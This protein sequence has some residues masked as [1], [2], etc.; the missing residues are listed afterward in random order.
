[1]RDSGASRRH[2]PVRFR[3]DGREG[4]RVESVGL[5]VG[6]GDGREAKASGFG[7]GAHHV[8]DHARLARVIEVQDIKQ[9]KVK[10]MMLGVRRRRRDY[11]G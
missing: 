6:V 7:Q 5:G 3:E 9:R 4:L 10:G 1:M 11:A 2:Q 8:K